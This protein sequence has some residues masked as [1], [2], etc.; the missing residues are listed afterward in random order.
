MNLNRYFQDKIVWVLIGTNF[1]FASLF[2]ILNA[3][4]THY[5]GNFYIPMLWIGL[6]PLMLALYVFSNAVREHSPKMTFFTRNYT[7]YIFILLS[8]AALATG[9]QYTPFPTID[10]NLV[11]IDAFLGFS[12]PG[13]V[14]WTMSHPTIK[15]I[16]EYCYDALD[17]ELFVAPMI[18]VWLGE[19]E[20]VQHFFVMICLGF[21]MACLIY[22][23]LPTA[24]PVSVFKNV[25]FLPQE[26]FTSTKY[27]EIH[28]YLP[29]TVHDSSLI[30]FPSMH[31]VWAMALLYLVHRHFWLF[32]PLLILNSLVILATMFL[33]WHYLTDVIAGMLV[34][35]IS[36]YLGRELLKASL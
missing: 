6:L 7:L 16:F 18:I 13:V 31:V 11:K 19:K 36:A 1:F 30:A 22:Y 26:H 25:S 29:L 8:F 20:T 23:F 24:A 32:Y 15:V 12:T 5:H 17:I 9:V 3:F 35:A 27:F 14:N 2:C 4:F 34:M 21:L 28:H 10:L 33:G